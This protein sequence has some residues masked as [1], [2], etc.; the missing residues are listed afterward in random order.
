ML[1]LSVILS[2][3]VPTAPETWAGFYGFI[4]AD[5]AGL[6]WLHMKATLSFVLLLVPFEYILFC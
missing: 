6:L 4:V 5:L 3:L 2:W 1:S